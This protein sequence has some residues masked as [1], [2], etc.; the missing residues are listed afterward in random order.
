MS[1]IVLVLLGVL[2]LLS[3]VALR[4]G[5]DG[6]LGR[7]V[8]GVLTLLLGGAAWVAWA[9]PGTA[10]TGSL[11]LATVLAVA[12]AGLG[13]G[14]V[15]VAV[16]DAADPG[17]PA[18]RGGPSDPDVLRGGAWIGALERIGVTATL[19][20]GWPEGLA[21]VLAVK[22]LGRYAELKDPAAAERFILG[23]LA[24]V[25]WAAG[26]AGVVVLLRS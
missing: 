3:A 21:V 24:S 4:A 18:V 20:V 5:T 23:T 13:G 2:V 10:S 9:A 25:L 6:V 11:V 17:G 1:G 19:L 26:C 8:A 22:G 7:V 16:L 12:A 14:A 15:A